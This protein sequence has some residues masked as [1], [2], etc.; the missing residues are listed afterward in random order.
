M[1]VH[2]L[3]H[4][5][6]LVR[7]LAVEVVRVRFIAVRHHRGVERISGISLDEGVITTPGGG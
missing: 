4:L 3:P 7:T 2:H 1:G 6:Y 5:L